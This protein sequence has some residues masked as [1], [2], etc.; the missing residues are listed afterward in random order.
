[1]ANKKIWKNI[2]GYEGLYQIS[3]YG[4]VKSLNYLHTGNER[5]LKPGNNGGGYLCV[6]LCK[7]GKVK[8]FFVH[9]LVAETFLENPENF[10]QV[11]HIDENKQNNVVTNLEWCSSQYNMTYNNKHLR[12]AKKIACYKDNKLVKI[13][14]A[15]VDVE[16]DGFSHHQNV[17]SALKGRIKSAYGYSWKYID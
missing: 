9:R 1:M 2:A 15:I 11:N 5:I 7:N 12:N 17:C 16:N 8:K 6:F 14:D 13:Y 4:D 3:N 10:P